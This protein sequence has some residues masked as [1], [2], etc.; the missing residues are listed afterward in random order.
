MNIP[1][2]HQG[3]NTQQNSGQPNPRMHQNYN[4][5]QSGRLHP[6]DAEIVQYTEIHQCNPLQKQ[7]QGKKNHMVISLDA[8]KAFDKI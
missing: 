8:E 1:H 7:T 2:E 5:P 4:S 6:W 3:K